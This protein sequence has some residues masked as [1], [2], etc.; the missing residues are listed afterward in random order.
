[1][2]SSDELQSAK[3]QSAELQSGRRSFLKTAAAAS[4]LAMTG[5]GVAAAADT[6]ASGK[7]RICVVGVVNSF[8]SWSWSDLIEAEKEGNSTRR[9]SFQTPFLGM[10]IT[11]VLDPDRAE[12]QKYAERLDAVAVQGFDDM[13][14]EV[15]GVIFGVMEDVPWYKF[16]ARPYIEAGTPIYLSRPFAY[17]MR[18]IDEIL[19]LVA[20]HN[21]P[22]MATAK[23]EHYNEVGALKGRL[24]SLGKL[25]VVQATGNANDFPMHFHIMYMIMQIF[26]FDVKQVSL[27]TD[28]I[29]R[30][31]FCQLTLHYPGNEEQPP[32]LCSIH[33]VKNRDQFSV[34]MFGDTHTATTNMMRSP[35]WQ[36]SLL[37]R[38]APQVIAMQRTFAGKSFEPLEHIRAKTRVWLAAYYS[39]LER[40]GGLVDVAELSADWRAPYPQPERYD[41]KMFR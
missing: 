8:T 28:G 27:I 12:A 25:S 33:G 32:F 35:D 11:H 2:D 10:D 29:K 17:C 7:L 6:P 40:N 39:H 16:L 36:D 4:A 15:D 13:V 5:T 1:M 21:A 22:I 26:G 14:G 24:K 18:D 30:N 34:S 3:L 19:E 9:G 41:K 38:Y 31:N 20:K 37:F 23:Y